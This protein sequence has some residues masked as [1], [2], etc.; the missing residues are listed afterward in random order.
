VIRVRSSYALAGMGDDRRP[1]LRGIARDRS[2]MVFITLAALALATVLGHATG[3][4]LELRQ[5]SREST[6]WPAV[7]GVVVDTRAVWSSSPR[8]GRSYWPL[9]HYRYSIDGATYSGDRVSFRVDYG[10]VDAEDAVAKYPAGSVAWISY[11]PGVPRRSVLEPGTW[12]GG[13]LM[14]VLVLTTVAAIAVALVCM[15]TLLSVSKPR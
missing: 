15:V 6:E 12:D 11:S 13:P 4:R 10:R 2:A 7:A 8:S 9:V 3:E 1:I 14:T 5:L